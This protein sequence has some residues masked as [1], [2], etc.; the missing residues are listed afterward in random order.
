LLLSA[1]G[2]CSDQSLIDVG[3]GTGE[4]T[5]RLTA[6]GA[7]MTGV[8][9]SEPMLALA[10]TRCPSAQFHA[11]D[12]ATW[13]GPDQFDGA[14]SRFGVMFFDDPASAFAN[15]RQQLSADGRIVWAIWAPPADNLWA[16]IPA[17][18]V[19]PLLPAEEAPDPFA[20]GPFA[21][22]DAERTR[23]LLAVAGFSDIN[24]VKHEVA[25]TLAATGGLE[26]AT[27][28]ASQIGPAS[29]AMGELDD[30]GRVA[31]K[32]AVREALAPHATGDHVALPGAIWLVTACA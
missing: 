27:D 30:A 10:G 25:I 2:D 21:L 13:Q 24:L 26:A 3:C 31:A 17:L 29:R 20:P 16:I 12:A 22:A 23:G 9:L 7:K 15:I 6:A 5:M 1:I 11:A 18:A 19:K 32:A 8:D 4:L 28:F 14:V